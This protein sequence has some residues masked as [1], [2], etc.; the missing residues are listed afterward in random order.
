MP[1]RPGKPALL[2]ADVRHS[3]KTG[4]F[5]RL[6][7][8]ARAALKDRSFHVS[9]ATTIVVFWLAKETRQKKRLRG[10][11]IRDR[12]RRAAPNAVDRL[13]QRNM[14]YGGGGG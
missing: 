2:V 7:H 13:F 12:A 8:S 3:Q 6:S 11:Q 5:S 10:A 9:G 1:A 14:N 4:R